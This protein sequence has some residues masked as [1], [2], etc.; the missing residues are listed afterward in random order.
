MQKYSGEQ[1]RVFVSYVK[2]D[3]ALVRQ[4]TRDLE[5]HGITVWLDKT[6][7][8]PGQ[9]WKDEIRRAIRDGTAFIACFSSNY[10]K[11]DQSYMNEEL[12]LA[13]AQMRLMPKDRIWF[14]P[15]LVSHCEVPD[16]DIGPNQ[17][18]SDLQY[19]ALYEDW[20]DSIQRIADVVKRLHV[21]KR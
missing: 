12:Q 18:F 5:K 13:I 20:H 9:N 21:D 15:V 10:A 4:L 1:G 16:Y 11:R 6:H 19:V 7:I 8:A 14:L 2:E 17:R 3:T